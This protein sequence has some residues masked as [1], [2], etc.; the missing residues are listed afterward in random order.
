[1]EELLHS[2][3]SIFDK[4]EGLLP[5]LNKTSYHIPLYQR[6]YKWTDKQVEKLLDD[7]NNFSGETGKFY[8]VQNITLVP[9]KDYLSVVDGQQ[10]LTTISL[11]LCHIGIV[12]PPTSIYFRNVMFN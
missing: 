6:G 11:G 8:C 2:V 7:I 1:M 5:S 10:R 4:E 3:K 12:P 9:K